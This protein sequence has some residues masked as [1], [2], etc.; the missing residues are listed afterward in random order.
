MA[1]KKK[2]RGK[3]QLGKGR[4]S[5]REVARQR[6]SFRRRLLTG[7]D[8][9]KVKEGWAINDPAEDSDTKS[10]KEQKARSGPTTRWSK[11]RIAAANRSL[12]GDSSKTP[13]EMALPRGGG[14]AKA[15]AARAAATRKKNIAA[16]KK[17][18]THVG[19]KGAMSAQ[20]KRNRAR[21]RSDARTRVGG[22]SPGS[23]VAGGLA[24]AR[25]R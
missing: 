3:S 12:A 11:A 1:A 5:E 8:P 25:G 17:A 10:R 18:G 14:R 22:G 2:T 4:W 23:R 9:M 16:S 24:R 21:A 20:D 15:S 6:A 13:G 19:G 7:P